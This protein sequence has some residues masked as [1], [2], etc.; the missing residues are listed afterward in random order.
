M[1]SKNKFCWLG[2]FLVLAINGTAQTLNVTLS[3][4]DKKVNR[5]TRDGV[6]TIVIDSK[7]KG[8]TVD[9]GTDDQWMKPTDNLFVYLVDTKRDIEAGYEYSH[10]NFILNSPNSAEYLLEIEEIL[11]NQVLYYTVI[12]PEQYAHSISCE[13]VFS[14]SAIYGVRVAYGKRFGGYLSYRWGQFKVSGNNIDN[15]KTDYNI[16]SAGYLGYCRTAITGGA[17]IGLLNINTIRKPLE[18]FLLVGGGYGEYARQWQNPTQIEGNIYFY[19]DYI[20]G[21]NAE[22]AVQCVLNR[23]VVVSVGVDV[24]IGRGRTSFDYQLGVGINLDLNKI[25]KKRI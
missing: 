15:I 20:K 18:M 24:L 13:Y 1:I 25:F 21:F 8:L 6:S 2:L 4:D 7:V 3:P 11:P 17:K 19:T 16:T 12:L 23:W 9:N 22:L 14:G 5:N 10:R